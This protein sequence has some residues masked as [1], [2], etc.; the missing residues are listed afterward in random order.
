[1][2]I[3]APRNP[4]SSQRISSAILSFCF[5][6][7]LSTARFFIFIKRF[8][9][10]GKESKREQKAAGSESFV[11]FVFAAKA[12]A[13]RNSLNRG[14]DPIRLIRSDSIVRSVR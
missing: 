6:K 14:I 13:N 7:F 12:T 11:E 1:M 5:G 2:E 3:L 10:V 4:Y 9:G 8:L